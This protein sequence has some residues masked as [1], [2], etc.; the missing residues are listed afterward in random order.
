MFLELIVFIEKICCIC[1]Y[2]EVNVTDL[3]KTDTD[4]HCSIVEHL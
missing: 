1:M 2:L 3:L 4:I